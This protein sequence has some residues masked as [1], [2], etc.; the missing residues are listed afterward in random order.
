MARNEFDQTIGQLDR[1]LSEFLGLYSA[2]LDEADRQTLKHHADDLIG[3]G[4][5][6]HAEL[7]KKLVKRQ[8]REQFL[9]ENPPWS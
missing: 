3:V 9:K 5:K 7:D 1:V 4:R 8:T 6:M 2:D